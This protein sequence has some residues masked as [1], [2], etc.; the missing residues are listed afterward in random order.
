MKKHVRFHLGYRAT[1]RECD[2]TFSNVGS[3]RKHTRVAHPEVYRARLVERLEKYG[4]L[5]GP[6][7][8]A[9]KKKIVDKVIA[10]KAKK[11][12]EP[13]VKEE[14]ENK[15]SASEQTK[16]NDTEK[17]EKSEF[18]A[19]I[20]LSFAADEID[21]GGSRFKFSCTVCKKR[22]S[23]YINMCRHRRKAHGNETKSRSEQCLTLEHQRRAP[24]PIVHNPEEIAA[25]YANV[26]H[27]IADNLNCYIDGKPDSLVNFADHIKIEGYTLDGKVSESIVTDFNWE[28]YNFPQDFHPGT[29]V[30]FFDNKNGLNIHNDFEDHCTSVDSGTDENS[31]KSFKVTASDDS[32]EKTCDKK[33]AEN[34]QDKE[35]TKQPEKEVLQRNSDNNIKQGKAELTEQK[36]CESQEKI[37]PFY[38]SDKMGIASYGMKV[39][40]RLV[41][42][43]KAPSTENYKPGE[44]DGAKFFKLRIA[45]GLI[46]NTESPAAR[47]FH[48]VC[49]TVI[50]FSWIVNSIFLSVCM[51]ELWRNKV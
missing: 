15:V 34:I 44:D 36:G 13:T 10:K 16:V 32:S 23:S 17:S 48:Q 8:N 27:N 21:D 26:S 42:G 29:T 38:Q 50:S 31:A 6:D 4:V 45:D 20:D 49:F 18:Q 46:L 5:R 11:E 33:S 12:K 19:D 25:F 24:S 28:Y 41:Q 3:L 43:N 1:C 40:S 39:L 35:S 14:K 9:L 51:V 7:K 47:T 30:S 22:F 2:E 37:V